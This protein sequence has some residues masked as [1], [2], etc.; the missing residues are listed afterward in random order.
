MLSHYWIRVLVWALLWATPSAL[1][2]DEADTVAREVLSETPLIDGHNDVP[3]Q[4][5][6]R[7]NNHM[8]DLDLAKSTLELDKP[9][10]TDIPR[11]RKGMLGGQF[12]SVYVP[13]S[14]EGSSAVQATVEQIDVVHRMVHHYPD[15]LQLA[16]TSEDIRR[17]HKE[18]KIASLV[19]IEGGHSI[20]S[21][22]GV[23]RQMYGLGARYMT[24]THSS[25]SLWAD[26]ATDVPLHGGLTPFGK[27]VIREMN[28]LGMIIDLSHVAAT[29]MHQ[30]LDVSKAPV[31][32]SH[33]GAYGAKAHPRNVPDDVLQRI[34]E[35]DGV[36]M[37]I[38]LPS[39]LE[40][41]PHQWYANYK[42]KRTYFET[43]Y[44]GDPKAIE[45]KIALW[46]ESNPA[47]TVPMDSVIAHMEHIRKVA[48]IDHI[49]IGSDF[50]GMGSAPKGLEDVSQYPA[51]FA[52][53]YRRGFSREDLKKIAG[54]N[55]LRVMKKVEGVAT[56]LQKLQDPSDVQRLEVDYE[57]SSKKTK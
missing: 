19:G 2:A 24:I 9:M 34:R 5:H 15:T 26:S 11:L 35:K 8:A 29:T 50:D 14:L 40:D 45:E 44:K 41:G 22:L 4:Y 54:E 12:W 28:R 57:I 49:G 32:F 27:E 13:T 6:S 3:W 53:L 30:S 21:S 46:K 23:L 56:E 10:H 38:F 42:A 7:V 31:I 18:G 20:G 17:I 47:P 16:L 33:S 1:L 51:L 52:E 36:V 55:V 39:Y 37:V 25:N 43:L 48:G